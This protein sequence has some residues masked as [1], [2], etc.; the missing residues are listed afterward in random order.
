MKAKAHVTVFGSV[1]TATDDPHYQLARQM[2]GAI[3]RLG[4]TVMTGGGPDIM[5]AANRGAKDAGGRSVACNIELP[6]EQKP[7]PYLDRAV[8][9]HYFFV[10]KVLLPR[11]GYAFVVLPGGAGTMDEFFEAFTLVQTGKVQRFPVIFLGREYWSPLLNILERM[12]DAGTL[13]PADL[14][15]IFVTDSIADAAAHLPTKAIL[16]FELKR[17][18][19]RHLRWLGECAVCPTTPDRLRKGQAATLETQLPTA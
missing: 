12:K 10:R 9:M 15:L 14:D 2:G 6:F 13:S 11:Y 4:F 19:R 18:L 7:I 3:A 1:R 16:P 17:I 8:T 5:E